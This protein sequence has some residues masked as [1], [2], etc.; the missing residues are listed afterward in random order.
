VT[1]GVVEGAVDVDIEGAELVETGGVVVGALLV[2]E[3]A[4]DVVEGVE[5]GAEAGAPPK[6]AGFC[7]L[8]F[9]VILL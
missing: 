7:Q 3:G 6:H 9:F 8:V 2:V 1:E 5:E 4:V